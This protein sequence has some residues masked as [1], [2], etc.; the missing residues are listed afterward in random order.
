MAENKLTGI[1]QKR[2]FFV[3]RYAL[4]DFPASRTRKKSSMQTNDMNVMIFWVCVAIAAVVYAVIIW[5]LV[6]YRK[7]K[8]QENLRKNKVN[9]LE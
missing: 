7:T 2:A 9:N 1:I 5:S 4:P 3:I 6:A 8:K